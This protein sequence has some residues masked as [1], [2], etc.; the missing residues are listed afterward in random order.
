MFGTSGSL[1]EQ[2]CCHNIMVEA[3]VCLRLLHT[4]IVEIYK[5]IDAGMDDKTI[6]EAYK[7]YFKNSRQKDSNQSSTY[8]TIRQ[9]NTSSNSCPKMSV[10]YSLSSH[11][12]TG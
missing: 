1:E 6:F 9:L 10:N 12:T 5:V 2:K 7:K 4:S 11:T 3:N 8:W